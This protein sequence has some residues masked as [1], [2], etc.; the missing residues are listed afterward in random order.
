M[1]SV[2]NQRDGTWFLAGDN[3]YAYENL[4]GPGGDGV[5]A[6]I[7]MTTGSAADWLWFADG[8]LAAA[9]GETSR[10]F[11]STKDDCGS[12]SAREFGDGLHL[13]EISLAG[14]HDSLI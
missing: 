10:S 5:L 12:A 7:A 11:P 3:V 9:G 1:V 14:G 8:L 6:P 4:E 13:A 2:T